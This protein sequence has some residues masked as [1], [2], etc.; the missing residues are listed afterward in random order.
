MLQRVVASK[1]LDSAAFMLLNTKKYR[2]KKFLTQPIG[3]GLH[4][5]RL[6][7][8]FRLQLSS[9]DS[10]EKVECRTGSGVE[11]RMRICVQG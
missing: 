2:C 10:T 5:D 9:E 8:T 11:R 6:A 1:L 4:C 7:V 3:L